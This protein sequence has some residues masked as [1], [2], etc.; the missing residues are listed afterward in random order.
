MADEQKVEENFVI[1]SSI[2]IKW[3]CQEED[4]EKSLFLRE[5]YIQ[6]ELELVSPDL[7]LYEI[8]NALRYNK[9]LSEEDVKEAAESILKLGI[10]IIVPTKEVMDTAI[11]LARKYDITV[12]DAYFL[13]LAKVIKFTLVTADQ[14]LHAKVKGK[15]PIKLLKEISK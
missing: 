1:D 2:V 4:T 14:K 8:A 9:N 11:S 3:F 15:E 12:Y 13:A 6:G 10:N 5:K 7:L